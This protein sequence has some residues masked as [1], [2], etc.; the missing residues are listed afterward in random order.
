MFFTFVNQDFPEPPG[1]SANDSGVRQ[2]PRGFEFVEGKDSVRVLSVDDTPWT[3]EMRSKTS[4]W[5]AQIGKWIP[6][7]KVQ[8]A[9]ERSQGQ[10]PS[11][12]PT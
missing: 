10:A 8:F 9:W 12:Q 1:G 5:L 6:F 11:Q 7:T 2:D 4:I 3:E